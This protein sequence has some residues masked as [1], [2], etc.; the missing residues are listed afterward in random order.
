MQFPFQRQRVSIDTY[1]DD[2]KITPRECPM[3]LDL[4]GCEVLRGDEDQRLPLAHLL[5]F[6]DLVEVRISGRQGLIEHLDPPPGL[7]SDGTPYQSGRAAE[8]GGMS[9]SSTEGT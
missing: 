6:N 3:A 2:S 7:I 9:A 8:L 4:L 1:K 5:L